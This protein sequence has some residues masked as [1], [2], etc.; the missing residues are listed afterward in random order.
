MAEP[1]EQP[2]STTGPTVTAVESVTA[3][4][5]VTAEQTA[6]TTGATVEDIVGAVGIPA[7]AAI[8]EDPAAGATIG[9]GGRA[10]RAITERHQPVD[11]APVER[12]RTRQ[13]EAGRPDAAQ[14][15]ISQQHIPRG[16]RTQ[17]IEERRPTGGVKD[18]LPGVLVAEVDAQIVERV[19]ESLAQQ[20]DQHV[21]EVGV[22]WLRSQWGHPEGEEGSD[23][24]TRTDNPAAGTA[25]GTTLTATR[26]GTLPLAAHICEIVSSS[27]SRLTVILFESTLVYRDGPRNRMTCRFAGTDA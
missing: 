22:S 13:I 23:R 15:Q 12:R 25:L 6:L 5:T 1:G 18:H 8:A 14:V 24:G 11:L 19:T 17:T 7:R 9:V 20:L 26:H 10:G 16:R 4:T 3:G 2:R 27:G 21:I